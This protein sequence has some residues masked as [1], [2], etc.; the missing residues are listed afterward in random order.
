MDKYLYIIAGCNGAGKT[1]ASHTIL[2][3]ILKCKEFINAD[4]IARGLS[5][6][7]PEKMAAEA[8]RIMIKRIDELLY[9]GISFA[10]E[11]TLFVK[12]Y[13]NTI[14]KAKDKGYKIVLLFFWLKTVALA[15]QRVQTR[16]EE[17]G[18]NIADDV[19]ERHYI[20]GIK[21]LFDVYMPLADIIM[22]FD[23]SNGKWEL[24]VEKKQDTEAFVIVDELKY[25]KFKE[26][27]GTTEL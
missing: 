9:E 1:T 21:N 14:C 7:Q 5:P 16:V 25:R 3:Q 27:Y 6:F 4:E 17:G 26:Y 18:D 22:I 11:T 2:P 8:D 23:N 19:I 12:S 24:I 20:R 10:F 15:K 13:R